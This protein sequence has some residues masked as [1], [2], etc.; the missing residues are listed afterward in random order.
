M[1]M[2]KVYKAEV[3]GKTLVVQHFLFGFIL[4]YNERPPPVSSEGPQKH[5]GH[6]HDCSGIPVPSAFAAA[7]EEGARQPRA[8]E[9]PGI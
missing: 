5:R 4:P 1:G 2:I 8:I 7:H 9:R 3:L 6:V